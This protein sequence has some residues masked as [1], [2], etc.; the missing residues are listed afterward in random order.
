MFIRLF[1]NQSGV[2]LAL[3]DNLSFST[4]MALG[5]GY[6]SFLFFLFFFF[7]CLCFWQGTRVFPSYYYWVAYGQTQSRSAFSL[8]VFIFLFYLFIFIFIF[9]RVGKSLACHSP[10]K[11]CLWA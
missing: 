9:F 3:S 10:G 8:F 4:N 2:V 6:I 5:Q 11:W 1:I 7:A